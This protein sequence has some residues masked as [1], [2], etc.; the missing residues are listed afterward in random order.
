MTAG[1]LYRV[2]KG[3]EHALTISA[4]RPRKLPAG[5]KLKVGGW[6]AMWA[7]PRASAAVLVCLFCDRYVPMLP[8]GQYSSGSGDAAVNKQEGGQRG[9]QLG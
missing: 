5:P 1:H 7:G 2:R 9:R 8:V 6:V 3:L 4:A